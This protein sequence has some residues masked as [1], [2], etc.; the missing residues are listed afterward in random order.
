MSKKNFERRVEV[1]VN[2]TLVSRNTPEEQ[3]IQTEGLA[4][5]LP[6]WREGYNGDLS[7]CISEGSAQRQDFTPGEVGVREILIPRVVRSISI[8][9]ENG[10]KVEFVTKKV[11]PGT[12]D[13]AL[14]KL[15]EKAKKEAAERYN[16]APL[17]DW[18]RPF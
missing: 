6:K 17:Q 5:K 15:E 2:G 4:I 12:N 7:V 8:V 10:N 11:R 16:T 18:E 13:K 3:R 14:N 1:K 9:L